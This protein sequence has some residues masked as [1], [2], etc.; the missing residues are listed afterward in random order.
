MNSSLTNIQSSAIL[1][2]GDTPKKK[3]TREKILEAASTLFLE[4]GFSAT[5]V[6]DILQ[7]VSIA[8]GTFYHHFISK[9][10]LLESV[11]DTLT[12]IGHLEIIERMKA[13]KTDSPVAKLNLLFRT[14]MEW[15]DEN[16]ESMIALIDALYKESNTSLRVS[17]KDKSRKLTIPFVEEILREGKKTEDFFF[18]DS[19]ITAE[20]I[21]LLLEG[22]SEHLTD[23]M[24]FNVNIPVSKI[25][26]NYQL[27]I[28]RILK[29]PPNSIR[30]IDW[31]SY[32][33][34]KTKIQNHKKER[35]IIPTSAKATEKPDS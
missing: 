9:E 21:L 27:A 24:V 26:A 3:S 22:L 35:K 32:N 19:A 25:I 15:K 13:T 2:P 6:D 33:S 8:K 11:T 34:I 23:D 20:M 10:S 12:K 28:E 14:S 18:E 5:S 16:I 4:R 29:L 17:L 31:N 30:L 1:E 7:K